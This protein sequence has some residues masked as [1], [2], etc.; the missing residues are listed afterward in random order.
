VEFPYVIALLKGNVVEVH[1]ILDQKLVQTIRF[2]QSME[3]RTLMQ[4]SGI[5]VWMSTLAKVLKLE[6]VGG[7]ASAQ[8]DKS[9]DR[10]ETNRIATVLAR[11]LIAGKDTVSAL[12]TTP[13]VLHVS[14]YPHH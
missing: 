8:D 5:K 10:Q 2:D 3:L 1:N 7:G 13:L 6:T 9:L 14:R 4:G 12:V 11:I